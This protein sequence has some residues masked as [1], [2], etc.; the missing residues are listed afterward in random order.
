M[1]S[2]Y[3]K[4]GIIY[5]SWYDWSLSKTINKSTRLKDSPSNRKLAN[6]MASGLQNELESKKEEFD[7]YSLVKGGLVKKAF[8]HFLKNNANKSKK[9][10]SEYKMFFNLFKQSFEE[11]S[12]VIDIT[13]IAVEDWLIKI[14]DMENYSQNTKHIFYKQCNHFL[15]FLFEYQYIPIFKINEVLKIKSEIIDIITFSDAEVKNIIDNLKTKKSNFKTFILMA[16]C[17]GLRPSSLITIKAEDI[18]IE[19]KVYKYW[20][21][22]RKLWVENPFHDDLLTF[23]KERKEEIKTGPIIIYRDA[24]AASAAF[25]KYLRELN[26]Y[27]K[28]INTKTFRKTFISTASATMELSAVSKLVGHDNITT[29]SKYYNKVDIERKRS[30]LKK[31]EMIDISINSL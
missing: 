11:N 27:R 19:K 23:L 31:L 25:R 16:Y 22:K 3:L 4:R 18:D 30:E 12:A 15:N 14:R 29:T 9:T 10:I 8:E 1:A 6:K 26:M 7:K 2:V 17:T 21:A 24:T 5:I 13:K 20:D 28:G